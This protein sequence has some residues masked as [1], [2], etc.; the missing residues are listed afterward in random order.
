MVSSQFSLWKADR[1]WTLAQD[2]AQASTL[3]AAPSNHTQAL[4][5]LKNL[6]WLLLP[7]EQSP[8]IRPRAGDLG[9]TAS[10]NGLRYMPGPLPSV[11]CM[12][13]DVTLRVTQKQVLWSPISTDEKTEAAQRVSQSSS[14]ENIHTRTCRNPSPDSPNAPSILR[15]WGQNFRV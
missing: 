6:A 2:S 7:T 11:L 3:T 12:V 14:R 8:F 9:L 5:L 10:I 1:V 13:S 4:L 15:A